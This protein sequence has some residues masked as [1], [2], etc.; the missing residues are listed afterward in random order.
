VP[1]A[2]PGGR[3]SVGGRCAAVLGTGAGAVAAVAN[4]ARV[5]AHTP[6]VARRWAFT[7]EPPVPVV[8]VA[9]VGWAG[10]GKAVAR[11]AG[12]RKPVQRWAGVAQAA[13]RQ[14]RVAAPAA[15]VSDG[16][17][18]RRLQREL[19]FATRRC[20]GDHDSEQ[21]LEAAHAGPPCED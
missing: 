7:R 10:V 16:T 18:L 6:V 14:A 1:A 3:A 13:A 12:V 17:R 21:E 5:R 9:T 20:Y 15:V 2:R 19:L 11:W 4:R 8:G